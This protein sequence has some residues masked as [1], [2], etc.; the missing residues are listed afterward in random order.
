MLGNL[1]FR[2]FGKKR[3]V[4]PI[5]GSGKRDEQEN[6]TGTTKTKTLLMCR[7]KKI[8]KNGNN[9]DEKSYPLIF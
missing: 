4:A 9:D 5:F 3:V 7:K 2:A 6:N 8:P 1:P